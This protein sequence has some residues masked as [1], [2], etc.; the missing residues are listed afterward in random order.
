MGP[1]MGVTEPKPKKNCA[2]CGKPR[3]LKSPKKTQI[4]NHETILARDPFCS[5]D[6]CKRFYGVK[7]LGDERYEEFVPPKYGEAA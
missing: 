3:T 6:C 7:V 1:Q 2:Q 4:P 5:T